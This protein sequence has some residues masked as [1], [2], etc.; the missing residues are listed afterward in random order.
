VK[1]AKQE[2]ER[3]KRTVNDAQRARQ[4]LERLKSERASRES[5]SDFRDQCLD[6]ALGLNEK[7]DLTIWLAAFAND[8][9]MLRRLE[10]KHG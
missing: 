10:E 7:K 9:P 6:T 4:R 3:W 5:L 2:L 1:R 8:P